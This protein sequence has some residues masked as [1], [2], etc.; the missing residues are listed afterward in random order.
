MLRRR[1]GSVS[2][3]RSGPSLFGL[4]V[5]GSPRPGGQPKSQKAF[6][7]ACFYTCAASGGQPRGPS[8]PGV[9]S[10][11]WRGRRLRSRRLACA[12]GSRHAAFV[13]GGRSHPPAARGAEKP[14]GGGDGSRYT[15]LTA[16]GSDCFEASMSMRLL[17]AAQCPH[18]LCLLSTLRAS[19]ETEK[20]IASKRT[21]RSTTNQLRCNKD[22]L[23][24]CSPE[25][26]ER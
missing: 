8:V 17:E 12:R 19:S 24:P 5:L 21:P 14:L 15:W 22:Q 10:A 18:L 16:E 2:T 6:W 26:R 11:C 13:F 20:H 23:K 1:R 3:P 25:P 9:E 4:L 7:A